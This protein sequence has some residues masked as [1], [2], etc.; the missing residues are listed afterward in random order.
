MKIY[1]DIDNTICNTEGSDY[2]NSTPRY[3]Q[4]EKINKLF[5]EGNNITYWT[6]RGG[7]SGKDWS[8]LTVRQLKEWNCK[9]HNLIMNIYLQTFV[10][11]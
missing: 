5:N 7:N 9:Y 6:A 3:D 4:I 2:L 10:V 11:F 1:V 8:H